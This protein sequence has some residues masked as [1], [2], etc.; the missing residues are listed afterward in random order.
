MG[1]F[2]I[3]LPSTLG[4]KPRDS[5]GARHARSAE[6]VPRRCENVLVRRPIALGSFLPQYL[7]MKIALYARV[8][9]RDQHC[10]QQ[11]T[12]LRNFAASKEW[13]DIEEYIDAG[14]S[15]KRD[16]RP[17]LDKLMAAC[18]RGEIRVVCVVAVDR[19]GRSMQHLV[20]SIQ[21]LASLG[22]RFIAINQGL[23]TDHNSAVARL[24]L[25]L[26]SAFADFERSL[27]SERTRSGLA[28][29]RAAGRVGGRPRSAVDA[30]RAT[31]MLNAGMSMKEIA[32]H[33]GCNASTVCRVL[34]REP[35]TAAVTPAEPGIRAD[36]ISA[37][38]GLGASKTEAQRLAAL[39]TATDFNGALRQALQAR[40]SGV[41][42]A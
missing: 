32:R 9:T 18:K 28:R 41:A 37:L 34:K 5:S 24:T 19:W 29:A 16:S 21:Q 11:L 35:Q 17:A 3:R 6:Q 42:A 4:A 23:D 14:V 33:F 25:N 39:T 36:V 15:G 38:T 1:I 31:A 2:L 8:S 13:T 10:E 30:S 22:V 27:I 7:H 12:A 40:Q 20:M 26:L